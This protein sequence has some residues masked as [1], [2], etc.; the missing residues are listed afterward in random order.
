VICNY[1]LLDFLVTESVHF[2][3]PRSCL[4]SN[5]SCTLFF[6]GLTSEQ[7]SFWERATCILLWYEWSFL[8]FRLRDRKERISYAPEASYTRC[9]PFRYQLPEST[10]F[11]T[12]WRWYF[13]ISR[14]TMYLIGFVSEGHFIPSFVNLSV[15][16]WLELQVWTLLHN[17]DHRKG[18]QIRFLRRF[19]NWFSEMEIVFNGS[20]TSCYEYAWS[21]RF[22]HRSTDY[23]TQCGFSGWWSLGFNGATAFNDQFHSTNEKTFIVFKDT[24]FKIQ[25]LVYTNLD[26]C[27]LVSDTE[28]V[29]KYSYTTVRVRIGQYLTVKSDSGDPVLDDYSALLAMCA[30]MVI[31]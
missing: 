6:G 24:W 22:S 20:V 19:Q 3:Y 13:S 15:A 28:L 31:R 12:D 27:F 18:T 5:R 16:S 2:R 10:V 7:L 21:S 17:T 23:H 25:M 4:R 8:V 29:N 1:K 11:Y 30:V 14:N 9:F 26:S